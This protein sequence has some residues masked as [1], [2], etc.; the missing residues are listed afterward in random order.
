MEPRAI[1]LLVSFHQCEK[2]TENQHIRRNSSSL[3][4][5]GKDTDQKQ[6]LGGSSPV[7]R[8]VRAGT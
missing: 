5:V 2:V 7:L 1:L 6:L 4:V 8:G 3:S